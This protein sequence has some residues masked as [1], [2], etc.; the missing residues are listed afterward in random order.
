MVTPRIINWIKEHEGLSLWPYY[1]DYAGTPDTIEYSIGYG[2]QI[3]P[4]EQYLYNG[5]TKQKANELLINDIKGSQA[6][7]K[8]YVKKHLTPAQMDALTDLVY[9]VGIGRA[10]QTVIPLINARAGKKQ[11]AEVWQNTGIYWKGAIVP[12][13]VKG[14]KKEVNLYYSGEWIAPVLLTGSIL[15]IAGI[16][17]YYHKKQ[18]A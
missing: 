9:G 14:R 13:L 1:D 5:I 12:A 2:H 16:Y 10:N 15:L 6:L 18:V 7:I 17:N 3:K 11:I 8:Q 4:S